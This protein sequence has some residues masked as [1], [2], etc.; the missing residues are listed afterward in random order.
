M[1]L[2]NA[3]QQNNEVVELP[4]FNFDHMHEVAKNAIKKKQVNGIYIQL[5]I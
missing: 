3:V 2:G 5:S 1:T 4:F